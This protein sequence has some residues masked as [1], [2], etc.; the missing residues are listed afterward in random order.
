MAKARSRKRARKAV[1]VKTKPITIALTPAIK[2]TLRS[3]GRFSNKRVVRFLRVVC[4]NG[5]MTI[6]SHRKGA[7]F[8]P[9]NACFA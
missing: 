8:V 5:R 3:K 6:T 7:R 2:A 1:A 9:S 4:V